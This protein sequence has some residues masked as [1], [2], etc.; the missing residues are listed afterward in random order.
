MNTKRQ[1]EFIEAIF[2]VLRRYQRLSERLVIIQQKIIPRTSTKK[3]KAMHQTQKHSKRL[4]KLNRDFERNMLE[5]ARSGLK[6]NTLHI[7][8]AKQL[9]GIVKQIQHQEDQLID[10]Y[11]IRFESE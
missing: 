9:M 8:L 3:Q 1:V 11:G 6:S 4:R 2:L 10:Y 5:Q 7:F